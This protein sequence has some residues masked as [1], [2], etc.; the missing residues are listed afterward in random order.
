MT[1]RT[2]TP[3]ARHLYARDPNVPADHRGEGYCVCGLPYR[4]DVHDLPTTNP[5]AVRLDARRLG[6]KET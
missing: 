6:E 3:R 5:D 1:H 4:S 2:A